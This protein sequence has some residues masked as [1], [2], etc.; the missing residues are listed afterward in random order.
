MPWGS[1]QPLDENPHLPSKPNANTQS[2]RAVRH[3]ERT[4]ICLARHGIGGSKDETQRAYPKGLRE[5]DCEGGGRGYCGMSKMVRVFSKIPPAAMLAL[6]VF[7]ASCR[8][9]DEARPPAV[10]AT[11]AQPGSLTA[12]L[13][14]LTPEGWSLYDD[15]VLTFTAENLYEQ[16][17]GRAEFYLAY[18]VV[19]MT[20]A[21]YERGTEGGQFIDVSVYDMGAPTHAFGVFSG[22]RTQRA[23]P[24]EL[25][26]EAYRTGANYYIW[27]GQYYIQIVASDTT[28]ELQRYGLEIARELTGVLR[29]DGEAVWGL[30]VLPQNDRVPGSEQF[31][32]VDAMAL[33]FLRNTYTA[34]YTKSGTVLMAFLS[35]RDNAES[36]RDAVD[37]YTEHADLYGEK[38]ERLTVDGVQLVTCDMGENYDVV[39]QKRFL[40]GGVTG[41]E[42]RVL[43]IQTAVEL[44][45]QV[46]VPR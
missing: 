3:P 36:A 8:T 2:L 27:K 19:D 5:D 45:H 43:A 9:E 24:L 37:R 35:R 40:V 7:A 17:D 18:D 22:E 4:A 29:D 42:D 6:L 26:R 10:A 44:Y 13:S 20:F 34:E 12:T 39:F 32:L 16:I 28:D 1:E 21:S 30:D 41:V 31:F 33:D 11:A 46:E 38:V 23:P 25:G 14:G 15:A